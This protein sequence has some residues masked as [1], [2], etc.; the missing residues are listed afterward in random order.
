MHNTFL[1][2]EKG[3]EIVLVIVGYLKIHKGCYHKDS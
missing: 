1:Q 3:S 2:F